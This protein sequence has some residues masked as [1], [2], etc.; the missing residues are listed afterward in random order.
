MESMTCSGC[1]ERRDVVRARKGENYCVRCSSEKRKRP[2]K[3]TQCG[4]SRHSS[5][6]VGLCRD[7][8]DSNRKVREEELRTTCVDCGKTRTLKSKYYAQKKNRCSSCAAKERAKHTPMP[9]SNRKIVD[10]VNGMPVTI[11]GTNANGRS[12][13]LF[14]RVCTKCDDSAY[15]SCKPNDPATVL[16]NSC[17]RGAGS[18]RKDTKVKKKH[19]YPKV[20]KKVARPNKNKIVS[21]QAI[22]RA[23]KLNAEHKETIA[24][25]KPIPEQIISNDDMIAKFL[26]SHSITTV[27][28]DV[29]EHHV[30]ATLGADTIF[31]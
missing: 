20:R 18:H 19:S 31:W 4:T 17:S 9:T 6:P 28:T 22:N 26:I 11:R 8:Y 1:G 5:S 10:T 16:C 25:V 21:E 29:M 15:I 2:N 14:L 12:R 27:G 13:T 7:C 23:R 30:N 3:C 24:Q